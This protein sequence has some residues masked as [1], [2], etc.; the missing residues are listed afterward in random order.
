VVE[1][2]DRLIDH[3]VPI[4][5]WIGQPGN[6]RRRIKIVDRTSMSAQPSRKLAIGERDPSGFARASI[7][8]KHVYTGDLFS[9]EQVRQH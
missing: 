4:C 1:C 8:K 7:V 9:G 6:D 2:Q 5:K 3:A